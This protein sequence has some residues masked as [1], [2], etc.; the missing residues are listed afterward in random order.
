MIKNSLNKISR[1]EYNNWI[2]N[3]PRF[4]QYLC[5]RGV[6][7]YISTDDYEDRL[8]DTYTIAISLYD[9]FDSSK[10]KITTFLTSNIPFILMNKIGD[11][12]T[13]KL[14][15]HMVH[16]INKYRQY[17]DYCELHNETAT[18]LGFIKYFGRNISQE[19]LN[20]IKEYS[21]LNTI[22][23][24]IDNNDSVIV[25]LTNIEKECEEKFVKDKREKLL[26]QIKKLMI[27]RDVDILNILIESEHLKDAI[28]T[29]KYKYDFSTSRAYQIVDRIKTIIKRYI[30]LKQ[31]NKETLLYE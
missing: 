8:Q 30:E 21:S 31:I 17:L 1:I 28:A 24:A 10:G 22:T 27:D 15:V 25:D 16:K 23:R 4:M 12:G 13:I 11:N 6:Q 20:K 5:K 2:V 18:D 19:V 7:K 9:K 3:H 26:N 14:P 29:I